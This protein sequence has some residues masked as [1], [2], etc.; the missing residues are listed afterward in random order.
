MLDSC[1]YLSRPLGENGFKRAKS[2][3]LISQ[4]SSC[5]FVPVISS[6]M[7]DTVLIDSDGIGRSTVESGEL[8]SLDLW[9]TEGFENILRGVGPDGSLP[10]HA[11]DEDAALLGDTR[12]VEASALDEH[13]LDA[14][15]AEEVHEQRRGGDSELAVTHA[16]LPELVAAHGEHHA[17]S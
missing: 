9:G 14:L 6:C 10:A 1:R 3:K 15:L 17:V 7:N 4:V 16:Q 2:E 12:R 13:D 11:P 5:L 8:E